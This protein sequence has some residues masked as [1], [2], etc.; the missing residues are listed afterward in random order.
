[1]YEPKESKFQTRN[2]GNAHAIKA[3]LNYKFTFYLL[4]ACIAACYL[5]SETVAIL[6]P[7]E[8]VRFTP[9]AIASSAKAKVRFLSQFAQMENAPDKFDTTLDVENPPEWGKTLSDSTYGSIAY[10]RSFPGGFAGRLYLSGLEPDKTYRL[11]FN[12]KPGLPGNAL[13][14]SPVEGVPNEYFYD[15]LVIQSDSHGQYEGTLGVMLKPGEYN[16]RLYV[17]DIEDWAI[18]LYRDYFPFTVE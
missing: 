18:V 3:T 5:R 10:R 6:G 16:V 14:P 17:K 4:L 1:M 11:T 13:L 7:D 8:I 12:G 15:F 9:K 2:A